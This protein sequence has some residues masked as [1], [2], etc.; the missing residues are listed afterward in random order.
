MLGT[1]KPQNIEGPNHLPS[2]ES[3]SPGLPN[4]GSPSRRS[5]HKSNLYDL[6]SEGF[7]V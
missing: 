7:R 3:P 2:L 6:G 5:L 1:L 4:L